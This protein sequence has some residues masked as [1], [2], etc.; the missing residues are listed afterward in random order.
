MRGALSGGALLPKALIA[1]AALFFAAAVALIVAGGV[2]VG[3]KKVEVTTFVVSNV[4]L[5]PESPYDLEAIAKFEE[6][7]AAYDPVAAEAIL[8][9][10]HVIGCWD[11]VEG[12]V[13]TVPSII[14]ASRELAG[15][16]MYEMNEPYDFAAAQMAEVSPPVPVVESSVV[17]IDA[18]PMCPVENEYTITYADASTEV[19]RFSFSPAVRQV[20]GPLMCDQDHCT[21][22]YMKNRQ[23]FDDDNGDDVQYK[24]CMG[25]VSGVPPEGCPRGLCGS[26]SAMSY[27]PSEGC[28][29]LDAEPP[30]KLMPSRGCYFPF[31]SDKP[32]VGLYT[33]ANV[34]ALARPLYIRLSN[35]PYFVLQEVTRGTGSFL[36]P[37]NEGAEE[38]KFNI[39]YGTESR[40]SR[41]N[42]DAGIALLVVGGCCFVVAVVAAVAFL[43]F[44][45]RSPSS[46]TKNVL[47]QSNVSD[48]ANEDARIM[49]TMGTVG[50]PSLAASMEG[51]KTKSSGHAGSTTSVT[52]SSHR[53]QPS[54]VPVANP[55]GVTNLLDAENAN[56]PLT[57]RMERGDELSFSPRNV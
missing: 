53:Q 9:A 26:C 55:L 14:P 38:E 41:P 43:L 49:M 11:A 12:A 21:E 27:D 56:P 31:A 29:V 4:S 37:K 48:E 20:S 52:I 39:T 23:F 25:V 35:D 15:Y 32:P 5:A 44:V 51:E 28:L 18:Y 33:T 46:T 30:H 13:A 40:E 8:S 24:T 17:R 50:G 22:A 3:E 1:A 57:I 6:A 10:V 2:I 19:F 42:E 54:V 34:R 47:G 7:V 16:I 36:R 45:L